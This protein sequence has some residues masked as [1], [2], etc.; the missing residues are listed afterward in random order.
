MLEVWPAP[1][2]VP[3]LTVFVV[4][5]P[6]PAPPA[7]DVPA[8]PFPEPPPAVA[9]FVLVQPEPAVPPLA[10]YERPVQERDEVPPLADELPLQTP[11]APPVPTVTVAAVPGT[12]ATDVSCRTPPPPPPPP[13]SGPPPP[14]PPTTSTS[15]DDTPAGTYQEHDE[16]EEKVRTV[17]EP[18]MLVDETQVESG[19]ATA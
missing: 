6:G 13:P 7:P 11:P 8:E 5:L 12:T 2:L 18:S 17:K 10:L 1:P 4:Q 19:T 14:P 9:L 16:P 15:I 3:E